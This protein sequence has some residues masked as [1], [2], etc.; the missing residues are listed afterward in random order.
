MATIYGI[1]RAEKADNE[2][3]DDYTLC[4]AL[5][6]TQGEQGGVGLRAEAPGLTWQARNGYEDGVK[7]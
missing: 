4:R 6:R 3:S 7:G 2:I 1:R 5:S